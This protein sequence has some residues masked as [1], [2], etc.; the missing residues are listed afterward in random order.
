[1]VGTSMMMASFGFMIYA[2]SPA[3]SN[4][5]KTEIKNTNI[6]NSTNGTNGVLVGEYAYFVDGGYIYCCKSDM[7]KSFSGY[8]KDGHKWVG[9]EFMYFYVNGNTLKMGSKTK[10]P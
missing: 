3:Y 6:P 10:L 5:E 9:N 1:M 8:S 7:L 4:M 2:I